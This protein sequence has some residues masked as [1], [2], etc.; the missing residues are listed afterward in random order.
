MKKEEIRLETEKQFLAILGVHNDLI[1][2]IQIKPNYLRFK[3]NQQILYAMIECYKKY[4]IFNIIKAI[5]C[6]KEFPLAY[7]S[8][9]FE[10]QLLTSNY[11][12]QFFILEK[13]IF[14]NYKED[15]IL[16]LTENLKCG[17]INYSTFM[18][19]INKLQ[20]IQINNDIHELTE[21]EIKTNILDNNVL[22]NIKNFEK[23]NKVLK[24]V[25]GDFLVIGAT[26]GMGKSGLLL[27][28]MNGLM[29][30]YQCIYFNMEMS[31]STIYKRIISIRSDIPITYINNPSEYQKK[32]I[33][34]A[35]ME[36][37]KNKIYVEHNSTDINSIKSFI[38]KVKNPNKHTI[39][40]ID[41][42]GLTKC[43]NKKSLYEQM[44]E[45]SK[46]L[47]QICLLYDCTIISASQLN[48][49]AY[50]SEEIT[51]SMLKDSG[52]LENSASKIILLYKDKNYTKDTF[53]IPMYLEIAKNRDGQVGIVKTEYNR[54]K[55]IFKE[56]SDFK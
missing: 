11:Q 5:E 31:K 45:V 50:N 16:N 29:D 15:V 2:F 30:D 24:L 48:R 14:D 36:I 12:K 51:L 34:K 7:Y 49:S 6:N 25:Q 56:M 42:L 54:Q 1:N 27:N 20:D 22:I 44:T 3:D 43:E 23:L 17:N 35:I 9:L 10:T 38:K 52:E 33:D 26:T 28:F 21:Q 4:N 18:T 8:E 41:H 46:Q 37:T 39:I 40:F 19:K 13:Q 55:Q 53:T 47:R 32:L